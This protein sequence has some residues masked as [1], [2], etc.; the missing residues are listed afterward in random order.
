MPGP[1][2]GSRVQEK[3]EARAGAVVR[4]ERELEVVAGVSRRPPGAPLL[5][6][7]IRQS[8]SVSSAS[9][10]GGPITRCAGDSDGLLMGFKSLISKD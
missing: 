6:Q 7:K 5:E 4:R 2:V 3:G 10:L 1:L 8:P 9:V